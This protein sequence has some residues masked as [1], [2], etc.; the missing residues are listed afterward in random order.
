MIARLCL[1]IR[2]PK[3]QKGKIM[4]VQNNEVCAPDASTS[5]TLG[6]ILVSC[7]SL[8]CLEQVRGN[9]LSF[10]SNELVQAFILTIVNTDY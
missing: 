2:L 1:Q 3:A 8:H 6:F 5:M 9:S 4:F 7:N 10:T